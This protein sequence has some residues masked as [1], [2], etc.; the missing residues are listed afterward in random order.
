MSILADVIHFNVLVGKIRQQKLHS[1][2]ITKPQRFGGNHNTIK[3]FVLPPWVYIS[4]KG[5]K[6]KR[7]LAHQV[8][9]RQFSLVYTSNWL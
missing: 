5:K 7:K 9:R 3:V 8:T 4:D 6:S 1:H 2:I